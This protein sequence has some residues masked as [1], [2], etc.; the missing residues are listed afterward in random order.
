MISGFSEITGAFVVQPALDPF[1]RAAAV[2]PASLARLLGTASVAVGSKLG[3]ADFKVVGTPFA[4]PGGKLG[5]AVGASTRK[6]EVT[7][8]PDENSYV[9]G[10]TA[11]RWTGASIFDPF[12]QTRRVDSAFAEVRAP[13]TGPAWNLPGARALDLS[14]AYRAEK[15]SDVG[16]SR[17]PK[18]SVRWQPLDEQLT[19]RYT[20]A[21][22][23]TAPGLYF[24]SGPSNQSLTT[25]ATVQ[26]ALGYPGQ[27]NNFTTNNPGL[28][29][30][31]AVT[32][33]AGFVFSPKALKNFTF[34]V[35]Y[36]S[37]DQRGVVGGP[38]AGAILS[39]TDRL[40]PASPYL[41]NVALKNFPGRPGAVAITQVNQLS[42]Y[43][44]NGGN[45]ADIYLTSNFINLS[46]AKVRA[47][48][49]SAEYELRT[50][51][52]GK[53]AFSTAATIFQSY[54]FKALPEQ[55]FYEYAGYATN[56]GTGQQGTIP[57]YR[58]YSVV[59][60]SRRSWRVMVGNTH[61]PSVTDIGVGGDTFANSTTLKPTRV[62]SYTTWDL[63]IG[64]GLDAKNA[65]HWW[66]LPRGT[67]LT[68]GVNNV[69]NRM[70]PLAP[71]AFTDSFVDP[72][73][74]GLI[75]RL[76]FVSANVKF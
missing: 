46:G 59:E 23:F 63:Q 44:K 25:A 5:F 34:T 42:D 29:P 27:A 22:S 17:V 66:S 45:A 60:W 2:D 14:L 35:D 48:D 76:V 20:Y 57:R 55:P 33:A 38:G 70:P 54:K 28:K 74:Y 53:F 12:D 62:N 67:K 40:G 65:P 31:T 71:Q 30:A 69:F 11:A 24:L 15:Y 6:E 4:L 3:S 49:V 72:G 56:G 8:Q 36:I 43:L 9:S 7:G 41:G 26:T 75:G 61:V 19:A 18:Y 47:F 1:A 51:T 58:A 16:N 32:R 50:A 37:A 64:C 21:A 13:L 73:T 10:P 68:L 39:T 52:F